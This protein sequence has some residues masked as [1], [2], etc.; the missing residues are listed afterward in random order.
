MNAAADTAFTDY[1][2]AD[3][4][5]AGWGRKEIAIA[6]T[7]MPGLMAIREE[8]AAARPLA[9]ARITG[10]LHMTIQTAVL[11][12]TL[13]ALGAAGPLGLVQHLLH[14]GPRRR[15]DRRRRR[16]RLRLQGREPRGVLGVHPPHLRV[17]GRR[18]LEHD[19]RRRRRRHAAPAPG[20]PCRG[21]PAVLDSPTS[22]EERVLFAAIR[23]RLASQ[24]GWYSTRLSHIKGVTEETTTGVHRLY[25]MHEAR[26]AALPGDQ[27]Q[28]LGHQVEVRQPVR[29]PRVAGRRHQAR[30]RRDGGRQDRPGLRLRRRRQGLGA[31]TA[32]PLG[33][34]VDHRDRPDLCAAG[35]DGRLPR[36]DH[37]RR[38]RQG[39]HLRHR[40]RELPRD[41]PRS[42]G[43]DEGSGDRLQHRPLRQRDRRR[44]ASRSTAGKRSSRRSTT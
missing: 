12:E 39:R 29:L 28:R 36:G 10:S 43:A 16:P 18:L 34:G 17:A 25:Q 13:T 15:R 30:H 14:A 32:R 24:P 37:G 27:R 5:L 6:E 33:P 35:R 42:H 8:F 7:E 23:R 19:P 21:D 22:E 11:I 4:G 38:L 9:G 1:R 44:L 31:G 20:H 26:R 41:H 40:D 2:V 3:L